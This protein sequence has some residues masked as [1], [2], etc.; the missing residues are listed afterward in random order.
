M[1]IW[2]GVVP[3]ELADGEVPPFEVTVTDENR[4]DHLEGLVRRFSFWYWLADEHVNDSSTMAHR[5]A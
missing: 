2:Q 3:M 5:M 1:T 4:K